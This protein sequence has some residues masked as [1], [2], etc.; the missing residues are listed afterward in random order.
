MFGPS[1]IP[2]VSGHRYYIVFVDDYSRT[3]WVYLLK[4]RLHVMSIVKQFLA[5]KKISFPLLKSV[6]LLTMHLNLFKKIFSLFV[7]P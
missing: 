5:E 3:S 6:C 4:D 2:S 1:R 7:L